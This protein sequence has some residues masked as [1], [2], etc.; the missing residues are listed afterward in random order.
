MD[1]RERRAAG[2]DADADVRSAVGTGHRP[3]STHGQHEDVHQ[4]SVESRGRRTTGVCVCVCV[5]HTS[6][7][8]SVVSSIFKLS[9]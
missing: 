9:K 5:C 6:S 4:Q 7:Q 8:I 2:Q 1:Q 3:A